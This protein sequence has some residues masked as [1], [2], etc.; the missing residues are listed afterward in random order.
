[1]NCGINVIGKFMLAFYIFKGE[2]LQQDHIK[3]CK[4]GTCMAMQKNFA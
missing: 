1:M 2:R 3:D 4:P